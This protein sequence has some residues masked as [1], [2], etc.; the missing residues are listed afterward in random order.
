MTSPSAMVMLGDGRWVNLLDVQ[1]TDLSLEVIVRGLSTKPRFSVQFATPY[2]IAQHVVRVAEML[3]NRYKLRGLHHDDSEAITV[4]VATPLKRTP[5]MSHFV[6]LVETPIQQAAYAFVGL[7]FL[8]HYPDILK[9]ADYW[10]GALEAC[11]HFPIAPAWAVAYLD[12]D[13]AL[14]PSAAKQDMTPWTWQEARER[15]LAY[16]E[17]CISGEFGAQE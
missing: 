15:F 17:R 7:P 12:G 10:Q 3:P 5:V 1:P 9:A 13:P 11:A 8:D 16:H 2:P 14:L 4:D 6:Q